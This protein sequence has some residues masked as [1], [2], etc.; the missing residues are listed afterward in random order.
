M[1]FVKVLF[2]SLMLISVSACSQ[3]KSPGMDGE[4]AKCPHMKEQSCKGCEKCNKCDKCSKCMK[5]DCK[6]CDKC[7]KH[8]DGACAMK[9]DRKGECSSCSKKSSCSK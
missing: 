3:Q 9:E 8:E 2:L 5:G 4:P 7:M 6:K 1:N